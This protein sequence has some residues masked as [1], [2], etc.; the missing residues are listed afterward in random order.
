MR[1]ER[2]MYVTRA[3]LPDIASSVRVHRDKRVNECKILVRSAATLE[4]M[5][6]AIERCARLVGESED[7]IK[8]VDDV[9]AAFANDDP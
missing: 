5:R 6:D 2:V 9:Q 8:R 4:G 7:A 3:M 1:E